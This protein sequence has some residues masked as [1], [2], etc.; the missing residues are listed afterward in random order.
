MRLFLTNESVIHTAFS[1]TCSSVGTHF[2]WKC[3]NKCFTISPS[4][5]ELHP[6]TSCTLS[7]TFTPE[8]A[9]VYS[10]LATCSY[11]KGEGENEEKVVELKGVGK[12]PHV[13][14]RLPRRVKEKEGRE[15]GRK[16]KTWHMKNEEKGKEERAVLSG[17]GSGGEVVVVFGSVAVGTS[18]EKWIELINVSAVSD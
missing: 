13:V 15:K 8:S 9:K 3:P 16:G 2:S 14:V 4:S 18:A 10:V 7:A 6:K 12:Y 11:G 17:A 5:G 1:C